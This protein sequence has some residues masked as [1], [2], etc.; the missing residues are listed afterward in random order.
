MKS[1][2]K[3]TT[4]SLGV[5]LI[6]LVALLFLVKVAIQLQLKARQVKLKSALK[7][8]EESFSPRNSV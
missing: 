7:T 5:L 2:L 6:F 8:K 3:L 1:Y 4:L